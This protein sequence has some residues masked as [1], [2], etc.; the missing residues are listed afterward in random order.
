MKLDLLSLTA[1][2]AVDALVTQNYC[3]CKATQSQWR[4]KD[5]ACVDIFHF[6]GSVSSCYVNSHHVRFG[7][8]YE[9]LNHPQH[10]TSES[11]HSSFFQKYKNAKLIIRNYLSVNYLLQ[12]NSEKQVIIGICY[13]NYHQAPLFIV[14]K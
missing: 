4:E 11:V 13:R 3:A 9:I 12:E 7:Q 10:F 5:V 6:V 2:H 1:Q 8:S 14:A